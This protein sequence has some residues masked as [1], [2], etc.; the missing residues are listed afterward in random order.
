MVM[1]GG[2]WGGREESGMDDVIETNKIG[3]KKQICKEISG[4]QIHF[5]IK[6]HYRS[7]LPQADDKGKKMRGVTQ[8]IFA[9][10]NQGFI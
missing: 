7:F 8:R 10:A 9:L 2:G 3:Q 6:I 5:Q 1:V 4:Q